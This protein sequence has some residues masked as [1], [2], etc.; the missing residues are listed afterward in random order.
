MSQPPRKP[1]P[2]TPRVSDGIKKTT[3]YINLRNLAT[4]I[5]NHTPTASAGP[6]PSR[7]GA[8]QRPI[9]IRRGQPTTP[10]AIRALQQRRNTALMPG[11][12]GRRRS[13]QA[14]RETPRDALRQLSRI[15]V[16]KTG[17]TP[18]PEEV[19]QSHQTSKRELGDEEDEGPDPQ[20]PRLSMPLG[21]L[22]DDE[23]SFHERPPRLSALSNS[24]LEENTGR[25]IEGA[26]RNSSEPLTGD[27]SMGGLFDTP[28]G[29]VETPGGEPF[30]QEG[31]FDD[32]PLIGTMHGETLLMDDN[33]LDILAA[34]NSVPR[35]R[36]RSDRS[37]SSDEEPPEP[38]FVFNIPQR[39]REPDPATPEAP[40]LDNTVDTVD[41][42]SDSDISEDGN[43]GY[44]HEVV[45]E[46][47][48]ALDDAPTADIPSAKTSA[49][50]GPKKLKE[51][52]V[53]R[54][55]ISYSS[56][57]RSSVK[58]LAM[59]LAQSNGSVNTKLS[60]DTIDAIMQTSDWFFEQASED[61][62]TYAQHSGRKTIDESDVF[63]LMK[64]QRQILP[65]STAFFLA[66]RYL[67]R[68]LLQ[69]I[70]MPAP[71]LTKGRKPRL[72]RVQE[73]A[74]DE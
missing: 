49:K 6:G 10:H 31:A 47:D 30:V 51:V 53:S 32:L 37:S 27:A 9:P 3:P 24:N 38:T 57:P 69:E 14:R 7:R 2:Q 59:A 13:G 68:E 52:K 58:K 46:Q 26:R 36:S 17:T 22:L 16:E 15:L 54:H 64:R 66:Q 5:Q 23:D 56:L 21:H 60:K 35:R 8:H 43:L 34:L 42:A 67:P 74:E 45:A 33:T 4:A 63:T 48:D 65:G 61:L 41:D 20:R 50:R 70:R 71:A 1:L 11:G 55:G 28:G 40:P 62:A 12:H 19:P 72:S 25:S 18:G 39:L 44:E 29:G 73:E